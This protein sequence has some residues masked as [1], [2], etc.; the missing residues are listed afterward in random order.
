[1]HWGNVKGGNWVQVV[2]SGV[3]LI[4]CA[5]RELLHEWKHPDGK[6]VSVCACNL[7]QVLVASGPDVHY[8]KVEPAGGGVRDRLSRFS[9]VLHLFG[10][11]GGVSLAEEWLHLEFPRY[12]ELIGRPGM[13][14]LCP[15]LD[16]RGW[17]W[18][19]GPRW[20]TRWRAWT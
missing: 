2:E 14:E 17:W 7:T 5:T 15:K 1:M 3:R 12:R 11:P 8:L 13:G 18:R 20:S 10:C 4:S 19:G 6:P 16:F 9:P